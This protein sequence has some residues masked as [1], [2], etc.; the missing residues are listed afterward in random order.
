[1]RF[2]PT[3]LTLSFSTLVVGS[4]T[5][6]QNVAR[7]DSSANRIYTSFGLDPAFVT[8]IGYGRVIRL[9]GHRVELVG[10]VGMPVADVDARD[11]RVRL[12][13][14]TSILHWRSLHFTGAAA[15][16][17]RGT[18]NTIYD[19]FNFGADATGG[20]GIYRPGWFIAG[21]FG[22]D[23]A[24]ITHVTHSE[25][26]RTYFFPEARDGW[27]LNA[28]GTFHYGLASGITIGRFDLGTRVG[29]LQTEDFNELTPPIYA[30]IALGVGF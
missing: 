28:G 23:K 17:T 2:V 19:G 18:E 30:S 1:M 12:H 11:F 4:A 16:I 25:W 21:E 29:W 10:E 5:G 8:S 22:F 7:L 6:Q 20:L 24:V 3:F 26:Y 13:A 27:Y 15:F 14:M 9:F